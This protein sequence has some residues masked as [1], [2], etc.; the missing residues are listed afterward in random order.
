VGKPKQLRIMSRQE[1]MNK[2][3]KIR[4]QLAK[5]PGADMTLESCIDWMINYRRMKD[6]TSKTSVHEAV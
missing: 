4:R 5:H 2:M 1:L 3:E 6:A